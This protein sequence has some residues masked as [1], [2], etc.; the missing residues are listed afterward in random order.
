MRVLTV[1][2]LAP[3][4]HL[5]DASPGT[6]LINCT[7]SIAVTENPVQ[8]PFAIGFMVMAIVFSFGYC[9]GAHFN[10]AVTL[11]VVLIGGMPRR[12]ALT[13]VGV[14]FA[15]AIL[16]AFYAVMVHGQTGSK[17]A[18]PLPSDESAV[19][20]MRAIA[21]EVFFTFAVVTVVLQVRLS[22]PFC[23]PFSSLVLS[24]ITDNLSC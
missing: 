19:G 7:I 3:V 14:Q 1:L 16:G 22:R 10:P 6:F 5:P 13:Y 17:L 15:G 11:G 4:R 9:S 20:M 2:H 12:K 24:A 8:A 23:N 21:A 18:A